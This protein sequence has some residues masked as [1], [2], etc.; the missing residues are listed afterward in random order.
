MAKTVSG[1][2]V[3]DML[4][5]V[6]RLVS[7]ELPPH[8]RRVS[9]TPEPEKL[10][11]TDA[12]RIEAPKKTARVRSQRLEDRIAELEAAVSKTPDD[13]E[14]DGSE[15]QAQHRPDRI[16][17]TRPAG[18]KQRSARRASRITLIEQSPETAPVVPPQAPAA[19]GPAQAA[20]PPEDIK[21]KVQEAVSEE[22]TK[23]STFDDALK[24][25]VDNSL[26]S[27]AKSAEPPEPRKA[28]PEQIVAKLPPQKT[29]ADAKPYDAVVVTPPP[30][31]AAA[32]KT[33]AEPPAA[34]Q[35]ADTSMPKQASDRPVQP[36]PQRSE[37][38]DTQAP[39]DINAETL[40]PIVRQ[41]LREEL[42]GEMGERITRNVR[43]LVRQEIQR[44]L[45]ADGL[46]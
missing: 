14:P 11:L 25:A 2:D 38:A 16:V 9:K 44:A 15:D 21:A 32:S 12:Q 30:V 18:G 45:A 4:S 29:V 13:W 1:Q 41:L 36:S 26:S 42:Q 3:E 34:R 24:A 5:S 37:P 33:V 7:S 27:E 20:E 40:R 43:K 23:S 8:Q 6:R 22:V 28:A 19:T 17:Y 46:D 10:V 39:L 31:Q 35:V